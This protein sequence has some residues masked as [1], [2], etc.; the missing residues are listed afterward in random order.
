MQDIH[1]CLHTSRRKKQYRLTKHP[2]NSP[3]RQFICTFN[4]QKQD[5][6]KEIDIDNWYELYVNDLFAYGMAF[7][8]DRD[9][10]LDAIHD[11]F[12]HLYEMGNKLKKP[13]N[14]K[15]YLFGALKNRLISIKRKEIALQELTDDADYE[16]QLKTDAQEL[17]DDEDERKSY[18]QQIDDLLNLLTPK[19]REVIYLHYL[20]E[21]SYEEIASILNITPKSVR[22]MT[23][24]ALERMQQQDIGILFLIMP[25]L[26]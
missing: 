25:Y 8:M 19:Q 1:A 26:I 6:L 23:Y 14:I 2:I 10:V 9:V 16:F 13:E 12:L 4:T 21:L 24:R 18:E 15:S 17:T 7:C 22:K 3:N 20:E 5:A 11:L